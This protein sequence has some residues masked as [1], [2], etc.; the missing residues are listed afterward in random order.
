MSARRLLGLVVAAGLI[1]LAQA[2]PVPPSETPRGMR[3]GLG[4]VSPSMPAGNEQARGLD[5]LEVAQGTVRMGA[6]AC[7]TCHGLE[8]HAEGS[9]AF[10]RLAGQHGWYLLKQLQDYAAG[11]RPNDV[12]AT[13]ARVLT[14]GQMQDV[15]AWYAAQAP[16]RGDGGA[17][18][19]ARQ[20][21]LGGALSAV[22]MPSRG[23]TA[24]TSCHG[25]MGEGVPPSAPALAG[26]FASYTALQLR[27]WKQ[28]ERRND[29]L[30]VM[31]RIARGMTEEEIDAAAAYFASLDP[32]VVREAGGPARAPR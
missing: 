29:P 20:R 15:A 8:G 13:V 14:E 2:Q 19:D 24:C 31:A 16:G 5:G 12:M 21:Q 27:L 22:G 4:P 10:P 17:V 1:G 3:Y 26:Q 25:R 9:G 6:L 23:V 11:R 28:G 32:N 30:G 7:H 18:A